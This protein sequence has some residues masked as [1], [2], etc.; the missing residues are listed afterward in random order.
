[1]KHLYVMIL[2][3]LALSS[4]HVLYPVGSKVVIIRIDDI[5]DWNPTSQ[6][7]QTQTMLLQYHIDHQVPALLALIGSA[8][9]NQP[10]L[11]DMVKQGIQQNIFTIAV[12][13]WKHVP[14]P[15]M[16][17]SAQI[18]D[19][20][21]AKNRLEAIFGVPVSA[22]VPPFSNFTDATIDAMKKN[23]VS[24]ISSATYL[25]DS[26]REEDGITHIPET[27]TTAN[28]NLKNN[29]WVPVSFESVVEQIQDSWNRYGLAVVLTHPMQFNGQD[30]GEPWNIYLRVMEWIQSNRG[31]IVPAE[32]SNSEM[33]HT[34]VLLIV[35]V[36]VAI[37]SALLIM[38]RRKDVNLR[39]NARAMLSQI[40]ATCR[41]VRIQLSS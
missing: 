9:G 12:H 28:V 19:M 6:Y 38:L 27:V 14:Y 35:V 23:H 41:A 22:F 17:P 36:S 18:A 33:G 24:L 3:S 16:S 31:T 1:M 7:Y 29:S 5:Q 10:Q 13:G 32:H 39:Q 20:G 11:I 4:S 37:V 25:G 34:A 2:L 8:F 21:Y 15:S 40:Y 26:P 30:K